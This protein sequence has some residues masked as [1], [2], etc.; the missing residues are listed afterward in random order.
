VSDVDRRGA[1]TA[2]VEGREPSGE[3]LSCE[4]TRA[5]K[6]PGAASASG[7][8]EWQNFAE[9]VSAGEIEA[10]PLRDVRPDGATVRASPEPDRGVVIKLWTRSGLG[11]MIRRWTRTGPAIREWR[12][13]QK[14]SRLGVDVPRPLA[15]CRLGARARHTE[16]LVLED[17]G[18]C[19]LGLMHVKD[20][21][22]ARREQELEAFERHVID[23]TAAMILSGTLDPDHRV[24]N[25]VVTAEGRPVRLDLELARDVAYPSLHWRMY[26][27]MLG[28][29]LG[30]YTF[31]VQP[32]TARVTDFAGRLVAR[33]RPGSRVLRRCRAVVEQML[34]TQRIERGIDTRVSL[35]W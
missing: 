31:A 33:V 27:E 24:T 35:P 30:S 2:S 19:R 1:A 32:D 6:A 18:E 14:L 10:V 15:Y 34:E 5:T 28:K 17:L 25:F 3:R 11:G 23:T 4:R 21:L 7:R 29:L 8:E 9:R 20:L 22:G 13:L 16:A 12:A 26:G